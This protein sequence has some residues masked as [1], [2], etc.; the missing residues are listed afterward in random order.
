M[1]EKL[2]DPCLFFRRR[3]SRFRLFSRIAFYLFVSVW[4]FWYSLYLL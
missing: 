4:N 3:I 1:T 2:V